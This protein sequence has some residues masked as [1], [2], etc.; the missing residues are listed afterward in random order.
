M[1][2][3]TVIEGAMPF[4][5]YDTT[6]SPEALLCG[7]ALELQAAAHAAAGVLREFN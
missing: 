3:R 1:R 4:A 6:Q 2:T 5:L 7:G